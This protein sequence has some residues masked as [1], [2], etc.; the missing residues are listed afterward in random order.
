MEPTWG[1]TT[2]PGLGLWVGV[3]DLATV[4]TEA[5]AKKIWR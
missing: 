5:E 4:F 1:G 3:T 2:P